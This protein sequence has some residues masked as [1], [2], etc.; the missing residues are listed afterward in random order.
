MRSISN[1]TK[2]LSDYFNFKIIALNRDFSCIE[3]YDNVISNEWNNIFSTEVFYTDHSIPVRKVINEAEFDLYYLNSFFSYNFSI[4]IIMLLRLG[5]IPG[6]KVILA[7]RGE[8]GTG[9]LSFKGIK[10]RVYIFISKIFRLHKNIIWH[11]STENE[12]AQ[13][14]N[15]FGENINCKIALDVPETD[16]LKYELKNKNVKQKGK[17][18]I[19]FLSVIN[20][21]KNLKFVIEVLNQ[22]N[23]DFI[24]DIYG[25]V[26]DEKYWKECSE[27]INSTNPSKITYKSIARHDMIT[28]I[29]PEYDLFFMPTLSENFGH[30]FFESLALG[31]PVLTTKNVI[32]TNL[33]DNKAGWN[34]DL[35]EQDKFVTLL[36]KLINCDQKEY[37]ALT[38]NCRGYIR[39][40]IN[41]NDLITSNKSLFE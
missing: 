35:K 34:Y 22:V 25:P 11:A 33:E 40:R 15:I 41:E 32:W 13:I 29:Y 20:R 9:A 31:C 27:L 39:S 38:N 28:E 10:K 36:E 6:K 2:L 8:L 26:K 16:L 4:K 5:L 3:K 18:R 23:G 30:V 17:L 24:L 14:K 21:V 7:P 19:L 12:A 37:E 1:I